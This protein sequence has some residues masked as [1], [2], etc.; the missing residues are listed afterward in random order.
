MKSIIHSVIAFTVLI[1]ALQT[2]KAENADS[3]LVREPEGSAWIDSVMN[4][5]SIDEKIAQL[6]MIRT[7][8]NKDERYYSQAESLIKT[9]NIGGLCFFQGGP[10]RQAT[11]T[12][13]YQNAAKT[14][15]LIAL[16]AEWGLGM[17]LDSSFTYP[18]QMT[19]GSLD[20]DTLIYQMGRQIAK[21]LKAIGTHIN[22]APVVDVNNNPLNPVINSRSFGSDRERVAEKGIAYMKG[23]QDGGII[24]TAKHFPGHGDTDSD[25]HY[26]L[27][28]IHHPRERLDSIE[29]YPFG[30]LIENGLD[31]TMVAHLFIPALD[32]NDNTPTTLSKKVVN[33]LLKEEMGFN[34]LVITDALDM[35]GVT[36][37]YEPGEIEKLAFMAGNDILLLPQDVGAAIAAIKK[38]VDDGIISEQEVTDRC[39]K[40][41]AYKWRAGLNEIQP[42]S[43]DSI[44][45]ILLD[46]RHDLLER[47]IY[48]EAITL[49]KNNNSLIPLRNLDTLKIAVVS[50][51]SPEITAFQEML[52]NY[53]RVTPF[54]ILG[55][56]TPEQQ[57]LLL[58]KLE[59]FNLIILGIHG[60]NIY[61]T[62][63]FG[64]SDQT[65]KLAATL[66]TSKKT[67]LSLFASP[68]SLALM[69]SLDHFEAIL[70]GHQD[71]PAS[72]EIAAQ[73]IMGSIHANGK[74]PVTATEAYPAGTGL[75]TNPINRLKYTIPE[76]VKIK[77]EDLF[78]IDTIVLENIRDE[79]IPGCQVLV[80]VDGK[81]IYHK[82]FG[83]HTYT[84]GDFVKTS[85]L[86]DLAS[87]TKIAA[88]TLSVMKLYDKGRIDIDQKLS[89]YLLFLAGTN[90]EHI[91]IRELMAHQAQLKPW[92]PFY[93]NTIQNGKPDKKLY[94]DHPDDQHTLK[95]A[96]RLYLDRNYHFVLYDTIVQ[97]EL[98]KRKEYKYSDLGFILLKQT[99]ENLTNKPMDQYTDEQFYR[100]L[101]LQYTCFNP[102][103]QHKPGNIVPTEQDDYF[104]NQLIHGYVHDPGA[105]M[106]GG[107][108]GHAGLFSNANE[109]AVIMQ[110]LL[111]GGNYGGHQYF[112]E[113]TV[114][115]F[116][117]QQFPLNENRRGIGFDK[118]EPENRDK[119]PTC[120][121][122]SLDSFGHSG[123]TGTYAWADPRY[124]LVYI[125]LSNRVNPTAAN[126]KLI[127][128]NTRT[129]IMQ[130]I[131]DA[132]EQS[133]NFNKPKEEIGI[134]DSPMPFHD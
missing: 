48:E 92:I 94:S 111:Q 116:T 49:L 81:V 8:S 60:T 108:S 33:D 110:M 65:L 7:Y 89:N 5:L 32:S 87:I 41:L 86:Y 131:Y 83:Y 128:K 36:Q 1:I 40:V 104:R 55:S 102:L 124:N 113:S 68:Y 37:G 38:A 132:I 19:L 90:K 77:R 101:G 4:S 64:I 93:L 24:A 80:A 121:S 30:K 100:P 82:A 78:L 133:G 54:N 119:G 79:A 59:P 106:L 11:L 99:I 103:K 61:P 120:S 123:F 13:R 115:Q 15:L 39:R 125:F 105:A 62:R 126:V 9:Y 29:F 85:D 44:S 109:L 66:A 72:N 16:D 130:V 28:V 46:P 23:L 6:M 57:D 84:K 63:Q 43:S 117:K 31:A 45:R 42:L 25:S 127:R 134:L 122:A 69:D 71:V 20:D 58:R 14:P 76:E 88:T 73:I 114:H 35:K 112:K 96:D 17:R 95:V 53:T 10:Q 22:F 3:L 47:N 26:T 67:I 34:G 52:G 18:F 12:N 118:P 98:R 107:V 91:N 2:I 27:P 56:S 129:E 50:A 21:Q 97:S 51:G 74:L 70:L 75:Y